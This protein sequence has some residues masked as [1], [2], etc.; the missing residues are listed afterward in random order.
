MQSIKHLDKNVDKINH[1]LHV[2]AKILSFI[3]NLDDLVELD[4]LDIADI[5]NVALKML[6]HINLKDSESVECLKNCIVFIKK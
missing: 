1:A 5:K 4:H 6:S 2:A 3:S